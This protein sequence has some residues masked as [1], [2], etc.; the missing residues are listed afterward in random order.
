MVGCVELINTLHAHLESRGACQGW[1]VDEHPSCSFGVQG[2]G[3]IVG[4]WVLMNT[5]HAY[6]ES[7]GACEVCGVE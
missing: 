4:V 7:R 5:P 2:E 6:L 1:W 3:G